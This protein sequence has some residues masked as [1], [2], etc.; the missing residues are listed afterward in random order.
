M[1]HPKDV[2]FVLLFV[3][4]ILKLFRGANSSKLNVLY[5][6]ND[7]DITNVGIYTFDTCT[8]RINMLVLNYRLQ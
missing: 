2:T 7:I 8:S 6:V 4:C 1:I 3:S 5:I